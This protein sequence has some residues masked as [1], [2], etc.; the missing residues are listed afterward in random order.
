M[1]GITPRDYRPDIDGLRAIAVLAVVLFHADIALFRGGFVGVDVFFV[2]SGFLITRII[3]REVQQANAN[4]V[5]FDYLRFY[6]RRARRLFPALFVTTAIAF[7]AGAILMVPSHLERFSGALLSSLVWLS[8][9]FFWTETGYF[10]SD[11]HLKPLLHTWS[12]SVEEQFY[13]IWP[14]LLVALGTLGNLRWVLAGIVTISAIS[15]LGAEMMHLSDSS[16][17]FFLMPFRIY[18][19]G[20]G[21]LLVWFVERPP[22]NTWVLE[23]TL[24]LGLALIGASIL[25]FRESSV[26]PGWLGLIPCLGAVGV[27]YAGRAPR[28]GMVLRNPAAVYIGRISYSLYLVHWPIVVF[29][30]YREE[31]FTTI[32]RAIVIAAALLAAQAL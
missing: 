2:I 4:N 11:A 21:A 27:I 16:A 18:E 14:A 17:A 24:F 29:Y 7:C 20:L 6:E 9:V 12:L 15:L 31:E 30:R 8:N 28:L 13:L 22:K 10:D 5:R 26:V 25:L 32:D 3:L 19:F 23:G 1:A